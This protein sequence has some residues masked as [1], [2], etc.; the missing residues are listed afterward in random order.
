MA[1][2]GGWGSEHRT[3][4]NWKTLKLNSGS[5]E[6]IGLPKSD[7]STSDTVPGM[8]RMSSREAGTVIV[9]TF[10][11]ITSYWL[12]SGSPLK[13]DCLFVL[14][15]WLDVWW[16]SF[17]SGLTPYLCSVKRGNELLGIAPLL[18]QG[19]KVSFMG[20]PDV[21]DYLDC[22]VVP[23]REEEFFRLLIGHLSLHGVT[24]LDL[25]PVRDDSAVFSGLI[26]LA[27]SAGWD[28][29]TKEEDVSME[30]D[31][32][33]TW[34]DFLLGL[35]TKERHEIRRKL[36]R[37]EG[38]ATVRLRVVEGGQEARSG[39]ETFLALL[40]S[41]R[42]E[43][44]AFMTARMASFFQSLAGA[45]AELKVLKLF[46]LDLDGEPAAA[47]LCFDYDSTVY[48]YNSGYDPRFRGL[49]AG[50]LNKVMSIRESI[51]SGS[52]RYDFLKGAE[53]YKRRMGGR[54]V[55]LHRCKVELQP[56]IPG[57]KS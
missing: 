55:P 50:L 46:F 17:G 11:K 15:A 47:A 6:D 49:S 44:A 8:M 42:P 26:P 10:E 9:E 21:C 40:R 53:I 27:K 52:K 2:A 1:P 5:G 30:L 13:W 29:T 22:I 45:M 24:S 41:S 56:G 12:S 51:G 48:L 57:A 31:L 35:T 3:V 18:L 7:K 36:R 16:N 43:K 20:S 34:E 25:G 54:P 39:M 19:D 23:G 33:P 38:A 14:P 32:P 37:L 28:F 4:Q